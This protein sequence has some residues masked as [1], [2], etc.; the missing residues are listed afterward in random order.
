MKTPHFLLP[1]FVYA[2]LNGCSQPTTSES[3][4]D[5]SKLNQDGAG[6]S[7]NIKPSDLLDTVW[8]DTSYFDNKYYNGPCADSLKS[9]LTSYSEFKQKSIKLRL[10]LNRSYQLLADSLKSSYLDSVGQVWSELMINGGFPFWQGT[11][12]TFEGHT[13]TPGEGTVACGYLVSTLLR[14]SDIK[15][16]RYKFAQLAATDGA[17]SLLGNTNIPA[18]LSYEDAWAT[19]DTLK[20]GL[21][22]V[23]LSNHVGFLWINNGESYFVHSNFIE[24]EGVICEYAQCSAAFNASRVFQI[25]PLS[26]NHF[27][28]EKWLKGED[29]TIIKNN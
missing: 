22:K 20:E 29:I 11:P 16:N 2:L 24:Y 4:N 23:G 8:Y 1:M 14:H 13:S 26:S 19:I 17:R 12:W 10:H 15:L 21:Y 7:L 9:N 5:S 18:L 3:I 27:L 25:V 28:M 6:D